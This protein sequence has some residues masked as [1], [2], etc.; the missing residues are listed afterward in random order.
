MPSTMNSHEVVDFARSALISCCAAEAF[1]AARWDARRIRYIVDSCWAAS[2]QNCS[3]QIV[4]LAT[5]NYRE[6]VDE[7]LSN[8]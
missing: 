7:E 1:Q 4:M 2:E 3:L 6:P 8:L 5:A